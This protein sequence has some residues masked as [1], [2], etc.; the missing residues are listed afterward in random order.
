MQVVTLTKDG[1]CRWL[2]NAVLKR[3]MPELV[4]KGKAEG[5]RKAL[6]VLDWVTSD[7]YTV[8]ADV[9]WLDEKGVPYVK[10]I[11]DLPEGNDFDV[12]NTGYDSIVSEEALLRERGINIVDKP[13]PYVRKL[14]R[15]F[16]HADPAFQ[17]V[18][19]CEPNHIMIKNFASLYPEDMILVQMGNYRERIRAGQNGKPI[20]FIPYVT[21]LPLQIDEVFR[22]IQE[23]YGDRA[24][25]R[26]ETSCLWAAG[27]LSPL[28]EILELPDAALEGI[29]YA[30]LVTSPNSTNKSTES[31]EIALQQRG[32]EITRIASLDEYVAFERAHETERV[33]F[34]RSP[35]PNRAEEPIMAYIESRSALLPIGAPAK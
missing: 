4:R 33:L 9:R 35:I 25:E 11:H 23:E 31:L 32:L 30:L 15:H 22:F 3:L 12:V 20:R 8:G 13:C 28:D 29:R 5:E 7:N 14:R 27:P 19:L 6:I 24:S 1:R 18:F 17:Y 16:E 10:T 21:F 2:D 34:V 26:V